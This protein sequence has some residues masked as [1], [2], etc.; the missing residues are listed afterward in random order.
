MNA[1]LSKTSRVV[2]DELRRAESSINLATRDTAQFLVTTLEAAQDLSPSV[3]HPTVRATVNALN[4]LVDSQHQL[5]IR[6]HASAEKAGAGLGLTI[7][8]WGAGAPKPA[9]TGKD[10]PMAPQ[11]TALI[12]AQPKSRRRALPRLATPDRSSGA[13][14]TRQ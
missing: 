2:A 6:A 1:D 14:R 12:E 9:I 8:D 7:V 5:A 3:A 13:A 11:N 10:A 4:A